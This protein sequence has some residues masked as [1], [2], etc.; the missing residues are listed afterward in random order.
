MASLLVVDDD[1]D[2]L[3]LICMALAAGGHT[4]KGVSG[5]LAALEIL[6]DGSSHIDLL[7]TDVVMPGLHGF[8]LARMARL[9]HPDLKVLYMSGA[10]D[11]AASKR[12]EGPKFGKMLQKPI[13]PGDLCREVAEALAGRGG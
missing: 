7:V 4:V 6:E 12:D 11:L 1:A 3:E 10:A 2:V 9:R 8:N 5:G 13:R